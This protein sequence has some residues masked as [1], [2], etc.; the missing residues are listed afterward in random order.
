MA[1]VEAQRAAGAGK[2]VSRARHTIGGPSPQALRRD[3]LA[4]GAALIRAR[5]AAV[6]SM[7]G[8]VTEVVIAVVKRVKILVGEMAAQGERGE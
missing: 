2:A 6:R 1:L 3:A 8:T 5:D 4:R 7:C